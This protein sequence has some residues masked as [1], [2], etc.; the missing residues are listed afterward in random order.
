MKTAGEEEAAHAKPIVARHFVSPD[1][2]R[3]IQGAA[4]TEIQG[5]YERE[6]TKMPDGGLIRDPS[7]ALLKRGFESVEEG[8]I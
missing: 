8:E 4:A 5:M 7:N 1:D 6:E 2:E 3:A